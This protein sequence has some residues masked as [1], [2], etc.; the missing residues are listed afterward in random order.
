MAAPCPMVWVP[1][2]V[3]VLVPDHWPLAR[4]KVGYVGQAVAVVLGPDRYGVVDAAEQ[5][6]V[7][8]DPLPVVVDP[9]QALEDGAPLVHEEYGTNQV[10]RVVARRRRRRGRVPRR[11]RRGRE[12]DRQPPHRGRGDRAARRARRVARGQ[13]HALELDADPAHLPRDPVDP[14]RHHRGEDPRRRARGRRR[15]RL[16]AAG[17]RRGG[18]RL[19]VRPPGRPA[20]QVD[21]HAHRRTCDHAPRPRPDRLRADR[22]QARR[23]GHRH[24]RPT[25][26]R[27]AARTT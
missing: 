3:E 7:E 4:E 11:R 10:L 22:R 13:A 12:A 21:G 9:E 1:P 6:L 18:A 17:L 19:L 14:A 16:Q 25:S 23:H 24:P 5:V 26:S 15:L 8:Y 20:G 2:G 27:T